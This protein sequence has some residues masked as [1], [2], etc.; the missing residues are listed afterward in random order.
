MHY[1]AKLGYVELDV[2]VQQLVLA[3][4]LN[5]PVA[6]CVEMDLQPIC[7]QIQHLLHRAMAA[8][9]YKSIYYL[10]HKL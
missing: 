3:H 6:G 5:V 4:L 8:S 2:L 9:H 10:F 1:A 7:S